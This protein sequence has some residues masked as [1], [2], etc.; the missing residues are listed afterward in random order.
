MNPHFLD[1]DTYLRWVVSFMLRLL[2]PGKDPSPGTHLI[3]GWGGPRAGLDDVEKRKFL[4]LPWLKFQPLGV[5]EYVSSRH[6]DCATRFSCFYVLLLN[7]R[8]IFNPNWFEVGALQVNYR[9]WYAR[10]LSSEVF[11]V[12]TIDVVM[13]SGLWYRAVW[14]VFIDFGKNSLLYYLRIP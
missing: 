11:T 12:V 9:K 3:E 1:L 14:R 8:D 2:T 10:S 13:F 7:S 4:T 5:V 6:T